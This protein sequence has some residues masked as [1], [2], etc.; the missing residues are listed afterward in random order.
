MGYVT[1]AEVASEFR[2]V[3]FSATTVP[4]ESKVQSIIDQ[5]TA[6]VNGVV[7]MRYAVPLPDSA[8]E[9]LE[10]LK[11]ACLQIAVA[12]V[13][14]LLTI[15]AQASAKG[16]QSPGDPDTLKLAEAT[17]KKIQDGEIKL[18]G[19]IALSSGGG[20]ASGNQKAGYKPKF[21]R[22]GDQW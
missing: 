18:E 20:V 15:K 22:D 16:D 10:I 5:A 19:A 3:T 9:A 17:L 7:R 12:R 13:K 4:P 14:P 8:T 2:S 21:K 11:T 6:H 1:V